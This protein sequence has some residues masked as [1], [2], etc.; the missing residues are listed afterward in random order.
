MLKILKWNDHT[1]LTLCFTFNLYMTIYFMF[2]MFSFDFYFLS[3][4][5]EQR[6]TV[7]LVLSPHPALVP[8]RVLS[9]FWFSFFRFCCIDFS[10]FF[11]LNYYF[12]MLQSMKLTL[13]AER[14]TATH[15]TNTFGLEQICSRLAFELNLFLYWSKSVIF[16]NNNFIL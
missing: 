3:R 7:K 1:F 6:N 2:V 15:F 12:I 9:K 5:C 11:I 8:H 13:E 10:L 16:C 14:G 4:S